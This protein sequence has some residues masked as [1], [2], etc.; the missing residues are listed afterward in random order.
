MAANQVSINNPKTGKTT[1]G[2]IHSVVENASDPNFT[3][4]KH[5]GQGC[6]DRDRQGSRPHRPDPVKTVSS[7]AFARMTASDGG[8][9]RRLLPV[10]RDHGPQPRPT[11]RVAGV[12]RHEA[13]SACW[14]PGSQG[15]V[16]LKPDLEGL[17]NAARAVGL[18]KIKREDTPRTLVVPTAV[19]DASGCLHPARRNPSGQ[20]A[21]KGVA[22]THRWSVAEMQRNQ[23]QAAVRE[24]ARGP[25]AG[26]RT[27]ALS[28]QK[29]TAAKRFQEAQELQEPLNSKTR[30]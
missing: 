27:G 28:T 7:T 3:S 21:G 5:P 26:D 1:L 4:S 16:V 9:P 2:T 15:F 30:N 8:K 19:K 24:T 6:R 12:F 18:R 23:R 20:G 14:P 25:K 13:L 17:F 11:L 29:Y 10:R 22:P